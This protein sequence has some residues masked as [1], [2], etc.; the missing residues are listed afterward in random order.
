[1]IYYSTCSQSLPHLQRA[2]HFSDAFT[3]LQ[4]RLQPFCLLQPQQISSWHTSEALGNAIHWTLKLL[5]LLFHPQRQGSGSSWFATNDWAQQQL[6]LYSALFKCCMRASDIGGVPLIGQS[7]FAKRFF[8]HLLTID[9]V[10]VWSYSGT[11]N[12]SI[13]AEWLV[14]SSNFGSNNI[15]EKEIVSSLK[16]FHLPH[17][18]FFL[19]PAKNKTWSHPANAWKNGGRHFNFSGPRSCVF[20]YIVNDFLFQ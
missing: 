3:H 15:L 2:V 9:I 18:A 12:L 20:L 10:L 17:A 5:S 13:D 16:W 8:L 19:L 11:T 4:C 1:M 14:I 6:P 7:F